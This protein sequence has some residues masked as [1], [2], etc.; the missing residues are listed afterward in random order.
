MP[1]LK[2]LWDESLW[3]SGS[4][5]LLFVVAS[6]CVDNSGWQNPAP[7]DDELTTPADMGLDE[8]PTQGPVADTPDQDGNV[9]KVV[10]VEP[11]PTP[12]RSPALPVISLEH[13]G[14]V[15]TGSEGSYCWPSNATSGK[16]VDKIPW[17]GV[18][19]YFEVAA[20]KPVVVVIDA[21]AAP[22]ELSVR[23]VTGSDEVEVVSTK[24]RPVDPVLD[25]DLTPGDYK[26]SLFG[27]WLEGDVFYKFGIRVTE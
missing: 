19:A 20:G 5:L 15:I 10:T 7:E 22:I 26:V 24:L 18:D 21:H 2:R 8:F 6:A 16:C 4:I 13:A 1:G 14:G 3:L 17:Y 27:L 11:E 23:V 25:L 12:G 9:T